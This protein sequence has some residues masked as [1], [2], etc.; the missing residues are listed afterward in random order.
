MQEQSAYL[1]QV[2][3]L[4]Q[5]QSAALRQEQCSVQDRNYKLKNKVSELEAQKLENSEL[6]KQL[7]D[8]KGELFAQ[9]TKNLEEKLKSEIDAITKNGISGA[10]A[11]YSLEPLDNDCSIGLAGELHPETENFPSDVLFQ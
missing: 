5:K 4:V 8:Q 6:I 10:V 2:Q 7:F 11:D 1:G 9:C 3:C